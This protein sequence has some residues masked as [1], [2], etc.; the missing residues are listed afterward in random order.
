MEEEEEEDEDVAGASVLLRSSL[1]EVLLER[2]VPYA[3]VAAGAEEDPA[4]VVID[5]PPLAAGRLE[6]HCWH[7]TRGGALRNEY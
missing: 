6:V 1:M 2:R 5:A 3:C 4:D 7:R